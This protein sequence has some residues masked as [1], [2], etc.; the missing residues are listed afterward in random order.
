M[1]PVDVVARWGQAWTDTH[2]CF[3]PTWALCLYSFPGQTLVVYYIPC[4]ETCF[5]YSPGPW[6]INRAWDMRVWSTWKVGGSEL[7]LFIQRTGQENLSS[8][9]II[10]HYKLVR[11]PACMKPPDLPVSWQA[12]FPTL[13]LP[14][15]LSRCRHADSD[16]QN[17]LRPPHDASVGRLEWGNLNVFN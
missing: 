16:G 17:F 3:V 9:P 1:H 12:L 13:P 15:S 6:N 2:A 11:E 7:F 8:H 10:V 5:I 4:A 14:L